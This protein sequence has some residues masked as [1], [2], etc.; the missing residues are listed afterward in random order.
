MAYQAGIHH[1][2]ELLGGPERQQHLAGG[3][4]VGRHAHTDPG[5]DRHRVA[6]AHLLQE[7][8][9]GAVQHGEVDV[10]VRRLVQVLQVGERGVAQAALQGDP[11][12]EHEE[13]HAD[14]VGAALALQAAPGDQLAEQPVGGRLGQAGALGQLGE[15]EGGVAAAEGV[16]QPQPTGQ[17]RSGGVIV[18]GPE[19]PG[20]R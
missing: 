13:L 9:A 7:Q 11:L 12:A 15:G 2:E 10:L 3:G 17:H 19:G 18:Y 20:R 6:P 16:Q 4:A 14:P 1:A 8:R 5:A